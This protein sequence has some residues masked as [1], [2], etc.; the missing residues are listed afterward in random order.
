MSYLPFRALRLLIVFVQPNAGRI[1][2]DWGLLDK[3]IAAGGSVSEG[4]YTL[5]WQ[6]GSVITNRP[7]VD[8]TIEKFG[9]KWQ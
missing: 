8:W 4:T 7:G 1:M 6:D 5:R 9:Q 2:S 3:L